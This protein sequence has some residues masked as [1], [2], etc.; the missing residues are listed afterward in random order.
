MPPAFKHTLLDETERLI[1]GIVRD[2]KAR[3]TVINVEG[4]SESVPVEIAERVRAADI[5]LKFLQVKAKIAPEV[6]ES[7][8]ERDLAE[9]HGTRKGHAAPSEDAGLNGHA[10]DG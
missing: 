8:F 2:A 6:T 9:F 1:H 10:G 5:A 3:R 4:K 7:E